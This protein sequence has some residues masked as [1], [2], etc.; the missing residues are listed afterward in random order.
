MRIAHGKKASCEEV[1]LSLIVRPQQV[2]AFSLLSN[3]HH[4]DIPGASTAALRG[5]P[6]VRVAL[7]ERLLLQEKLLHGGQRWQDLR[8]DCRGARIGKG[9]HFQLDREGLQDA[10]D[11]AFKDGT[12][13]R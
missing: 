13:V 3:F 1:K 6:L 10:G 5:R 7:F 8:A 4:A 11:A 12:G 9:H 2:P